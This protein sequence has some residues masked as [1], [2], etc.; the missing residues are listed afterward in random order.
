MRRQRRV[1]NGEENLPPEDLITCVPEGYMGGVSS[2]PCMTVAVIPLEGGEARGAGGV[3]NTTTGVER[4]DDKQ[5]VRAKTERPQ[6]VYRKSYS[7][8]G[9]GIYRTMYSGDQGARWRG[10]GGIDGL[11]HFNNKKKCCAT[12][13]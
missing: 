9:G 10:S 6:Y 13:C 3:G 7:V 11:I 1:V 4:V 8:G 12:H 5:Y 2:L